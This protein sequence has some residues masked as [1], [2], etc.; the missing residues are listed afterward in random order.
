MQWLK[1]QRKWLKL[2]SANFILFITT[3]RSSKLGRNAQEVEVKTD[4]VEEET[5]QDEE[6]ATKETVKQKKK[7]KKK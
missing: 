2:N 6:T 3:M 5:T 1:R 4:N 7:S